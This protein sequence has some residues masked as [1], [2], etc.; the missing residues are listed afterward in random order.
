ME[1]IYIIEDD[2]NIMNLLK[3]ALEGF[4]QDEGRKAGPGNL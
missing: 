4:G 2:E 1:R 3:I